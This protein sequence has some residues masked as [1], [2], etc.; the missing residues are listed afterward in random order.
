MPKTA[1]FFLFIS[2]FILAQND[3][4]IVDDKYLEDQFYV[5]FTYIGLL[6]TPPQISKT[7]FSYGIGLGFVKDLPV[8]E[9]RNFGFGIGAGYGFGTYYFNVKEDFE[10]PSE[11]NSTELKS[12]K[13]SM[14]TVEF[15]VELRFRTSSST[16]YK[17]WRIYPGIKFAYVFSLN[18]NLKQREDFLVEDVVEID[19]FLYGLTLSGGFNKWNLHVYYGLNNLFSESKNNS[20]EINIHEIRLGLIFYIL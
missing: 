2:S 6:N 17:F 16:K 11:I 9:R 5:N 13:V 8:N 19:K 10:T 20:Y 12:N 3:S 1:I 15:P 18:T 4:I 7:G 14:H